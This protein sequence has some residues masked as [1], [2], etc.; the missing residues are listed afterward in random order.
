MKKSTKE[1]FRGIK[2][3]S[4]ALIGIVPFGIVLGFAMKYSGFTVLQCAFHSF[5]LLS[6]AAQL[7][8]IQL[9][10]D[11]APAFIIII[12]VVMINLR[13]SMYS[14]SFRP[15]MGKSS[16]LKRLLAGFLMT[17][18]AYGYIMT[19]YEKRPDNRLISW[20]FFG[21]AGAIYLSR[22]AGIFI[23]YSLGAV[24]TAGI[25]IDFVIP[26]IFTALIVPH[27]KG[28]DRQVAALSA[29]ISSVIL[30]PMLP[31][32]SGLLVSIIIGIGSGT[33]FRTFADRIRSG[34]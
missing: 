30:V 1:F 9:Y 24:F 11:P 5:S 18:L 27:L 33:M 34:K 15:V 3:I 21:V 16:F 26:L 2:N 20:L 19:E 29:T 7:A 6:G 22:Q 14:L 31:L 10:S 17:D 12:T 28:R 8:A 23:G 25:L 13:Y 32:R 4:P